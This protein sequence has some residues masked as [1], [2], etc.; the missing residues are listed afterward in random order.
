M[1]FYLSILPQYYRKAEATVKTRQ[2]LEPVKTNTLFVF[3]LTGEVTEGLVAAAGS[4][5]A[6]ATG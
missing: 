2:A 4:R 5:K 3:G 1:Y 6:E